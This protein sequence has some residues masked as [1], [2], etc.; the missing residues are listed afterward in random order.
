LELT[1][2][3]DYTVWSQATEGYAQ[4]SVSADDQCVN[5]YGADYECVTTTDPQRPKLGSQTCDG[6][7]KP[8]VQLVGTFESGTKKVGVCKLKPDVKGELASAK[9]SDDTRSVVVALTVPAIF[10]DGA[11]LLTA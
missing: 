9:M 3:D 5:L 1:I 6:D 8:V 11:N 10:K 4:D 7:G 2:G